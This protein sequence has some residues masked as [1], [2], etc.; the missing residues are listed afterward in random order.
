MDWLKSCFTTPQM[1]MTGA[2]SLVLSIVVLGFLYALGFGGMC[3]WAA[4][5]DWRER[6]RRIGTRG[7]ARC[8]ASA[9][10]SARLWARLSAGSGRSRP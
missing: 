5:K 1:Q 9:R 10:R 2:Q 6:R 3:A 8:P 4:V 7:R